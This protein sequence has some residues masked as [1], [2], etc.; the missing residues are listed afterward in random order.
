MFWILWM[1]TLSSVCRWLALG[2]GLDLEAVAAHA[3]LVRLDEVGALGGRLLGG[4]L[5]K[6]V[7]AF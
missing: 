6:A 3:L 5:D 4:E 2:A 7:V 1:V